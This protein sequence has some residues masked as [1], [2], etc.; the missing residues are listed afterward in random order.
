MGINKRDK[1]CPLSGAKE[2][3]IYVC[4]GRVIR[5]AT[6][7]AVK[8]SK[9]GRNE[10]KWKSSKPLSSSRQHN[11]FPPSFSLRFSSAKKIKGGILCCMRL[12]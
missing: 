7:M 6:I 10:M 11:I 5:P 8:I 3:A 1:I 12:G 4:G 9:R 2:G